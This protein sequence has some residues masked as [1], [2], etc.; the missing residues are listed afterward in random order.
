MKDCIGQ[1]L[2]STTPLVLTNNLSDPLTLDFS[3]PQ[4][5]A[6]LC[7]LNK[8]RTQARAWFW[9]KKVAVSLSCWG[10][11]LSYTSI[12]LVLHVYYIG[13]YGLTS[14]VMMQLT[15]AVFRDGFVWSG[16]S[17]S[18]FWTLCTMFD[19]VNDVRTFMYVTTCF[20]INM[21][22]VTMLVQLSALLFAYWSIWY[23]TLW[24]VSGQMHTLLTDDMA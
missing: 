24:H 12:A 18:H 5:N 17:I 14:T 22:P 4:F 10:Q 9:I 20:Q 3:S 16:V 7:T 2:P 6:R 23:A 8:R 1:R 19:L 21:C 15:L 11:I 13:N